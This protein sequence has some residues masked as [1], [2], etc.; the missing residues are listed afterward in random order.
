MKKPMKNK[1]E[2]ARV[3]NAFL[4]FHKAKN[5]VRTIDICWTI[6]KRREENKRTEVARTILDDKRKRSMPLN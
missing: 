3:S 2:N 5:N 6:V 4:V 1:K